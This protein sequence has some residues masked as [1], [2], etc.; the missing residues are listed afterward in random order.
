MCVMKYVL[1]VQFKAARGQS[2]D[3]SMHVLVAII[4]NV[5]NT[6][7]ENSENSE[8]FSTLPLIWR[9]KLICSSQRLK[10]LR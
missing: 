4:E 9:L 8:L 10:A 3:K 6:S 1:S 7:K 5:V 2:L